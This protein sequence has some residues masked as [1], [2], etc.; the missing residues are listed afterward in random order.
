MGGPRD[1]LV[2]GLG[3]LSALGT[4]RQ[5][6]AETAGAAPAPVTSFDASTMPVQVAFQVEKVRPQPFM[7]RRKDLKVM[8]QDARLAVQAAGLALLDAGMDPAAPEGWPSPPE[9]VGLFMGVG[10][11][12]GDI[13]ELAPVLA[14]SRQGEHVDLH[15]LGAEGIGLIPPLSSLMTLPNMALAHV[16]INFGLMGPGEALSPWGV[17]GLQALEAA[18]E[19]IARGECDVA[20]V[21]V[22]DSDIDL[23]G[24]STHVRLGYLAGLEAGDPS[25]ASLDGLVMGEGACFLVLEARE[26]AHRRAAKVLGR[27]AAV[28]SLACPAAQLPSFVAEGAA[29]VVE[30]VLRPEDRRVRVTS[31]AGHH[32]AWRQ[33]EAEALGALAQAGAVE[34]IRP[35][36][37]LGS[38]VAASGLLD[39]GVALARGEA[40]DADAL[41]GLAWGPGGEW[42][43]ARIEPE[44]A[45]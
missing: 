29:E 15:H 34:I 32:A 36:L 9:E 7:K 1:A 44:E 30:R 23:G 20:L 12:P 10:L 26:V 45:P 21:G 27:V 18:A 25:G 4:G 37:G 38:C 35:G 22:A 31:A 17:S 11:E 40:L 33:A 19:A 28:S 24:L 14:G 43:A 2:T 39:L 6:H 13:L 41:V 3:L 16:S 42:A 8:S 5:E